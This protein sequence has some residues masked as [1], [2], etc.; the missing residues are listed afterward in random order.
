MELAFGYEHQWGDFGW[1]SNLTVTHNKNT[2]KEL[3]HGIVDP[4]NGEAH[5]VSEI[6]KDWL[7]Q[8]KAHKWFDDKYWNDSRLHPN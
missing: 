6:E 7:G 2:I 4:I 1:S 3:G 8:P 5:E